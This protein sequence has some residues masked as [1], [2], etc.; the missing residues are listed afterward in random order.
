MK[1]KHEHILEHSSIPKDFIKDFKSIDDSLDALLA[2][3]EDISKWIYTFPKNPMNQRSLI[4]Q[5]NELRYRSINRKVAFDILIHLVKHDKIKS[6]AYYLSKA[7]LIDYWKMYRAGRTEE[8]RTRTKQGANWQSASFIILDGVDDWR[9]D[10]ELSTMESFVV[11]ALQKGIPFIFLTSNALNDN[12]I[13]R[14]NGMTLVSTI[15]DYSKIINT[16]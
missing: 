15:L 4:L 14:N 11:P 2:G 8:D 10:W 7:E 1:E 6:K 3:K 13:Q 5:G 12:F 9:D 16:D